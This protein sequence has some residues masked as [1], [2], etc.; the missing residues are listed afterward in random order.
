MKPPRSVRVGPHVYSVTTE[1]RH[2][3]D[4][5]E[6][7][8]D[9]CEI[10]LA[11]KQGPSQLRETLLHESLHAMTSL[12]GLRVEW[13][14]DRDESCVTRLAP[15]LLDFLRRNPRVVEFLVEP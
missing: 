4:Y 8:I 7:Q 15:I 9:R 2:S 3:D 13:G 1:Q 12:A 10:R 6:T 14:E 11:G 5:G